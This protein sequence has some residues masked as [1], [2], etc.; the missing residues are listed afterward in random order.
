MVEPRFEKQQFGKAIRCT[1]LLDSFRSAELEPVIRKDTPLQRQSAA[2]WGQILAAWLGRRDVDRYQDCC[3]ERLAS[4][5]QNRMA[6]HSVALGEVPVAVRV[7][8]HRTA[9]VAGAV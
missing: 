5:H 1:G 4:Y 8:K 6:Q 2:H 9:V 3:S 7:R